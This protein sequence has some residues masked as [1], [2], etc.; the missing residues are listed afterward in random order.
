MMADLLAWRPGKPT[1]LQ[2]SEA[3]KPLYRRLGFEEIGSF[4]HWV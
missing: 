3:A 2:P 1:T 4:V